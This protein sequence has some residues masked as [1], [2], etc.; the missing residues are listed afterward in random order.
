M[1]SISLDLSG[2]SGS[3]ECQAN[4]NF[5]VSLVYFPII[6][7]IHFQRDKPCPCT[8]CDGKIVKNHWTFNVQTARHVVYNTEEAERT[9]VD[10][11][12]DDKRSK[13]DGKVVTM[14]GDRAE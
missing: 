12:F 13:Q 9:R 5:Q 3:V 7:D 4:F 11:V 8:K 2:G 1:A 6:K 14:W 10:L